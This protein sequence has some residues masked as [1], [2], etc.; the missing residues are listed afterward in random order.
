MLTVCARTNSRHLVA[1]PCCWWC[2]PPVLHHPHWSCQQC[3]F[4]QVLFPS[5]L[6]QWYPQCAQPVAMDLFRHLW[7]GEWTQR[8]LRCF[9]TSAS[10]R[11]SAQLWHPDWHPRA[12]HRHTPVLLP[13][14][15]HVR[16][17]P[18]CAL[19]WCHCS[20][21]WSP[22][23]CQPSRWLHLLHD[24]FHRP[25]FPDLGCYP[26]DVSCPYVIRPLRLY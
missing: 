23:P 1:H 4:E 13:F 15:I 18:D 24:H 16:L 21:H 20:P 14:P 25:L 8:E 9:G 2:A 22:C 10:I 17:L 11:S 19:L 6:H 3:A 7:R 5:S 26:D 12:V